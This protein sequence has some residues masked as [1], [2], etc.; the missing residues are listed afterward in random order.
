MVDIVSVGNLD[1]A[2]LVANSDNHQKSKDDFE[3][4]IILDYNIQYKKIERIV[5]KHWD[6]LKKDS[7]LGAVLPPLS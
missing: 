1:Q 3:Y 2:S 4:K 5:S 6:I 7:V